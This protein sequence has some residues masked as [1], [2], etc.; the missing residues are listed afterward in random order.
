LRA[1]LFSSPYGP[2]Y[3]EVAWFD[4]VFFEFIFALIIAASTTFRLDQ[5]SFGVSHLTIF[6]LEKQL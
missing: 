2:V 3:Y 6:F 4:F 5:E 1:S